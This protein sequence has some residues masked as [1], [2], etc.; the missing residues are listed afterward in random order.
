MYPLVPL[1]MKLGLLGPVLMVG[2]LKEFSPK[3]MESE[4]ILVAEIKMTK[5]LKINGY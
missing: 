3:S 4:L 2:Y 1:E 5:I